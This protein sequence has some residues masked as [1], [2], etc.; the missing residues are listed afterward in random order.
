MSKSLFFSFIVP[1]KNEIKDITSTL[2]ALKGLEHKR[3]EVIVVDAS[4]DGTFE[5]VKKNFSWVRCYKQSGRFGLNS[6]YNQ[7]IRT[8]KGDIVVLLTADNIVAKDFL[9]KIEPCYLRGFDALVI[10]GVTININCVFPL[11][12]RANEEFKHSN[13]DYRPL[14]SEGYSCRKKVAIE[15]GLFPEGFNVVGGTDNE[16]AKR[17][18]KIAKVYFDPSIILTHIQPDNLSV[19]YVQMFNRGLASVQLFGLVPKDTFFVFYL[20]RILTAFKFYIYSIFIFP[21]AI[22][23]CFFCF[24]IKFTLLNFIKV[25]VV[26]LLVNFTIANGIIYGLISR[27]YK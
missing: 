18:S 1:S 15:A 26:D 22:R 23:A 9:T 27:S 6:A 11:Y 7:G 2:E 5:I 25:L 19:F 10:K 12:M 24:R 16:F 20:K 14:W 4:D 8:A 13:P 17:V 3:Y 21:S